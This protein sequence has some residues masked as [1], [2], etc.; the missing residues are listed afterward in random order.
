MANSSLN[1]SSLDFDN[2]KE[3]FKEYLKTQTVF[4][5]YNFDGSN[6]SVLLDVMSYNSYLNS[7][8]LNMI[9]SEMFL[10]SAQKYESV[11]S[12]AKELNY[13]P[14]SAHAAVANVSFTVST[15]G[16]GNKLTIPKG[17]RFSG[18]NSNGS[19][20]FVTD[21]TTTYTSANEFFTIQNLQINEGTYFQ[22]SFVMDYE[23]ETQKF[24]LSNINIDTDSIQVVV[25]ENST[26]NTIFTK[27][28]TLFG[29]NNTSDIYFLQ[30]AENNKYEIIFGD[31]LFGRKPINGSTITI[32]YIV[33][34]G[35]DGNGVDNFIISDD[36]TNTNGGLTTPSEITVI[37]PSENGSNQESIESV[38]FIAPRYFATQQRA[39]S[40]DDYAS[41]VIAEFGGEISDVVIYGGQE[42]EP[43]LYGR[44][45]VCLKPAAGTIAPNYIKDRITNYLLPYIAIPNRIVI[46]DPEYFYCYIDSKI[47]YD[48]VIGEKSVSEIRSV[49]YNTISNYSK[50]NLEKF[51]RDLR[52]SKLICA[53]DDSDR[54]IVSNDTD[55]RLIKR[56]SPLLGASR[57]YDIKTNNKIF[58]EKN[59]TKSG[60]NYDTRFLYSS[61]ISSKFTYVYN[62]ISYPLSY[63]EDDNNGNIKIYSIMDNKLVEISTVG[64]INYDTGEIIINDII[65]SQYE[66]HISIYLKPY[67]K[68]IFTNKN[69]VLLIDLNDVKLN[70]LEVLR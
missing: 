30:G 36:L 55:I 60:T 64:S 29:L 5:D 28:D 22:D 45:V 52:Y 44:V 26:G 43:K 53:I 58:V 21:Q 41:L 11:V 8:Y 2:L 48:S 19:Y 34:N 46:S 63:L 35:S 31:G 23:D 54:N 32:S 70:I 14:R 13:T 12:H 42:L 62:G 18:V 40:S 9:A 67:N 38:R 50:N 65:V 27:R 61:L 16:V 10:D 56:I 1:L 20:N 47:Q 68:D 25:N 59:T 69:E 37:T 3:N 17:T 39:I 66:Q 24:V 6:I 51:N 57:S 33:T 4:K 49:V 15:E 7:F